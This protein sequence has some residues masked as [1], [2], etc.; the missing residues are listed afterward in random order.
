MG[1]RYFLAVTCPECKTE[2]PDVYY[3][4]TCGFVDW[5]CPK[6]RCIVDLE[7]WTGISYEDCSNADVIENLIED[8]TNRKEVENGL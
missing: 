1:D 3:A 2:D 5:V 6:C 4:P 8:L 7:E